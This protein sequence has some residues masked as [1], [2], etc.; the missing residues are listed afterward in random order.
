M[1]ACSMCGTGRSRVYYYYRSSPL[2]FLS[3][4]CQTTKDNLKIYRPISS[5]WWSCLLHA[6]SSS[7]RKSMVRTEEP[8][9]HWWSYR[10]TCATRSFAVFAMKDRRI[11]F[12]CVPPRRRP[13]PGYYVNI[14][15]LTVK[16][17]KSIVYYIVFLLLC[18]LCL[19]TYTYYLFYF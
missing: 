4:I 8:V 18:S 15:L 14:K 3:S 13:L 6:F 7:F 1:L 5:S 12:G 11:F 17:I 19:P 10:R 2:V 16:S 9:R